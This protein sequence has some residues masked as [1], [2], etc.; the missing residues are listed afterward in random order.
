MTVD[1]VSVPLISSLFPVSLVVLGVGRT[2]GSLRL[3]R[4]GPV[5]VPFLSFS[6]LF[7][8]FVYIDVPCR[9]S[10]SVLCLER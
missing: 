2:P 8:G 10:R 4:Q 7:W 6:H 3:P 5:T 9:A 1:A